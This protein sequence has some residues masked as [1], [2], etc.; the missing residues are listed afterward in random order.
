MLTRIVAITAIL[1]FGAAPIGA[2]EPDL[3]F[4]P[5]GP[6]LYGFD[7][8]LFK[9]TL[10]LDGKYQGLYPLIDAKTGADLTHPPGVFSFYRVFTT[11]TRYGNAARDWPTVTRLLADGAVAVDWPAAEEHPLELHAVYRWSAADTLDLEITA[12]P[13]RDMP[14]FELF[15]SSYFTKSFRASVYLGPEEDPGK[16]PRFVP[17][18]R[19]ADSTGGYVM[20][21]RDEQSLAMVLDGR[22]KIPPSPVDWAEGRRLFSPL[23]M[24]RDVGA[25]ITA[26]MMAPPQ[27]CFAVSC[28]WNP[29]TADAGGYRSLYLSLFGRD[30]EANRDARAC[31]RLVIGRAITDQRAVELYEAY[32]SPHK[33]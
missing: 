4:K 14:D 31:C 18:D 6:G 11:N 10:K 2:E 33:Q 5:A 12:V 9:G 15:M 23:A 30:L 17:A 25:D 27:D 1:A 8:G 16:G 32:V 24:R 28:P 13:Q 29:A 19:S 7:T 3:G 21:P 22:W 20:F 26:V